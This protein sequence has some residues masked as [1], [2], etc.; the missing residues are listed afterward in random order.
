MSPS[1]KYIGDV[2]CWPFSKSERLRGLWEINL[3]ASHFYP[4]A[5]TVPPLDLRHLP[6]WLETDL[7]DR[8]PELLASAQG[9]GRRVF[10]VELEGREALCD[11]LFG[12]MGVYRREV[13]VERFYSLRPLRSS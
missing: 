5:N 11:G 9:A 4:N 7:I 8:R 10:A 1:A 2:K 3:E 6:M 13:I 12:N